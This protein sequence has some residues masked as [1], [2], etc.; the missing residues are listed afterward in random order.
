MGQGNDK[1]R[2]NPC[3]GMKV[4]VVYRG[5]AERIKQRLPEDIE[6]IYP[7]K[8]TDEEL[9]EL[10]RDVDVI[11]ATRLSAGVAEK[12]PKL[13]LLQKTGAGVDDMPFDALK[14]ETYMANTS[15][16][17]PLPLAEGAVALVLALAKRIVPRDEGFPDE[18]SE[19]RGVLF[20]DKTA[21]ILGMGSIGMEV[22]KMLK[23]LGMK[24]VA[25][26]RSHDETLR[27]EL[28]LE[29]LGNSEEIDK[30]MQLSDF[31]IVTIPLTP[32]TTGLVGEHEIRQM[33]Q[34]SYLINV[35]RAAIVQE[36]PLYEALKDGHLAGAAIDVWWQPH[37]WDPLWNLE[38]NP[39]S[40]YPYWELENV[41]CI[42]HNIGFTD[43]QSDASLDIM[44]ENIIR[45][46]DGKM[47]I[48]QV[49]KRLRY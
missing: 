37:F 17:N 11:V 1:K 40:K 45:Q 49:D 5:L 16:S 22:A 14:P 20:H 48:N 34:G 19:K 7:E 29:W 38:G 30:L 46:R 23:A 47:P 25:T 43:S 28:G 32:D 10:A 31:L 2:H 24:V 8:G 41:I 42:P 13:K 3:C 26:R 44:V 33:K 21:G 27:E 15:G 18:R 35:A 6:V 39:A 4:L 12:A 36:K 9:V